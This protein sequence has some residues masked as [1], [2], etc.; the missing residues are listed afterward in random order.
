MSVA[1]KMGR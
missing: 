1:V